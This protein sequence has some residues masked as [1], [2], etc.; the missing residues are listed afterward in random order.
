ME[1]QELVNIWKHQD[2]KLEGNLK[3]NRELLRETSMRKVRSLLAEF[4]GS[5]ITEIVVDGLFLLF[6][7]PF[8]VDHLT[9]LKFAIPALV[10]LIYIYSSLGFN[11]YKLVLLHRINAETPVVQTQ[12]IL[13]RLQLYELYEK[14]SLYIGIPIFAVAFV[15]VMAKALFDFDLYTLG[16]LLLSFAGGS[17]VVAVII[18][19][20]LKRFP[21]KNME[22]AIRFVDEIK[23]FEKE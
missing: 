6:L 4:K 16:N 11:I 15:I 12:K 21:D 1:L 17:F 8:L 9:V 22:K 13:G 7:M 10:L 14:N 5:S 2:E 19:W 18:V 23:A 3:I 20:L